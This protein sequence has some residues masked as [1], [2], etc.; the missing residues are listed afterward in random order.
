MWVGTFG[1][2]LARWAGTRFEIIDRTSGLAHDHVRSI[3]EDRDGVIWVGTDGGGV[4]RIVH[5]RVDTGV[6]VPALAHDGIG[7]LGPAGQRG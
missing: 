3:Y 5:G 6:E 7:L 1:A 4:S 2:G